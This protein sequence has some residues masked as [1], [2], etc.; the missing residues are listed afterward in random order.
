[1][2]KQTYIHNF[3]GDF[4]ANDKNYQIE[5]YMPTK[6]ESPEQAK[7]DSSSARFEKH[8]GHIVLVIYSD[9][10][11]GFDG[12]GKWR[13][14]VN[15]EILDIIHWADWW[16]YKMSVAKPECPQGY[17]GDSCNDYVPCATNWDELFK[18]E[19]LSDQWG[20]TVESLAYSV[21]ACVDI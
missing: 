21:L 6:H 4:W 15:G 11:Q 16:K 18:V 19:E 20:N 2:S 12:N 17:G 10:V 7:D 13:E 3:F 9:W 8:D 5:I 14:H 1:M